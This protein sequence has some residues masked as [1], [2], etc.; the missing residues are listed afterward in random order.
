[1]GVRPGNPLVCGSGRAVS[2]RAPYESGAPVGYSRSW[3]TTS[4]AVS[5]A[6][7]SG[8]GSSVRFTVHA[9]LKTPSGER[10]ILVQKALKGA[11]ALEREDPTVDNIRSI[12]AS[13]VEA[14]GRD[15]RATAKPRAW[16][17]SAPEYNPG[18]LLIF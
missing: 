1:M 17:P 12:A 14:S 5:V 4:L 15:P 2:G 11:E 13:L 10:P 6:E 3:S 9:L 16:K 8:S 18:L 7:Y